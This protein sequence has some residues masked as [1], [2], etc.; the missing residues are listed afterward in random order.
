MIPVQMRNDFMRATLHY[1]RPCAQCLSGHVEVMRV[2]LRSRTELLR[3]KLGV[4]DEALAELAGLHRNYYG[5]TERGL[6][7][8]SLKKHS[9]TGRRT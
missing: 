1:S 4:S 8:V 5:E 6:R 9:E 3:L 7:N 2:T